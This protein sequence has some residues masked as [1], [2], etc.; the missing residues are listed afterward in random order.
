MVGLISSRRPAY[1][2]NHTFQILDENAKAD[3][4]SRYQL[5]LGGDEIAARNGSIPSLDG[6]RALSILIVMLSHF[7]NFRT[8]PF[9][10]N[11]GV[12]VFF[13][14]SG[15]LIARLLFSEMKMASKISLLQFYARRALRLYPVI[16]VYCTVVVTG[17]A[18]LGKQIV[19]IEPLSVM[20]YFNN[21]LRAHYIVTHSA[22]QMPF[23]VFW[24]LSIEEHF[25]LLFPIVVAVMVRDAKKIG[26]L[27]IAVC[28]ICL[29]L[30]L[31]AAHLHPDLLDDYYIT[32]RT[33][34]RLDLIAYGVLLAVACEIETGRR[35][36]RTLG[37]PAIVF[38]ALLLLLIC[39][40][41][42]NVWFR[43]TLRFS[44]QSIGVVVLMGAV[45]FSERY[46][47]AQIVL[48][49]SLIKWV[50]VLSYSLYIWHFAISVGLK[51]LWP[52]A[53][54]LE[55]ASTG[56]L[57]SFAVAAVSYYVIEKPFIGLRRHYG[58]RSV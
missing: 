46:R 34:F 51:V 26:A 32:S 33:E 43:D 39:F 16:I 23:N 24:S 13:A 12:L 37:Q 57:L 50:G 49:F 45:L 47:Y 31:I 52:K 3:V 20:F 41:I 48:N 42:R 38:S 36:V 40:A 27:L 6:L 8:I 53:S 10:G 30:R 5:Y 15:F 25:Y 14:I 55:M 35:I 1:G 21:Y 19:W 17:Y 9:P 54:D 2:P 22:M 7:V 56:F 44:L 28:L 29:T 58:S 18:I 11:F 4:T